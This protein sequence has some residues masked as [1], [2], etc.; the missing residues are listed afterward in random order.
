[1]NSHSN[2]AATNDVAKGTA[3]TKKV[4][5]EIGSKLNGRQRRVE[6]NAN[7]NTN[8]TTVINDLALRLQTE[9]PPPR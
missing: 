4:A 1:M 6:K 5:T 9:Q 2:T 3:I 8:G 7:I